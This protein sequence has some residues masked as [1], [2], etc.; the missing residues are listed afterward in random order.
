MS[1]MPRSSAA[2]SRLASGCLRRTSW[3][4]VGWVPAPHDVATRLG[5]EEDAEVAVRRRLLLVNDEP[6]ALCDSY[7]PSA[8]AGGTA[9][10]EPER[11]AGGAYGLIE[12]AE[13]PIA[14]TLQ[15]SIDDL[16]CRMPTQHEFEQLQLD[17]G[18]PVVRVLR[19]VYDSDGVAVEVQDTVAAADK[20][21][22]RY[23]V[24]MR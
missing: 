18:V 23:E 5:V 16:E 21:L 7:Y 10:A 1:S 4:S 19:T 22:L 12:D 6:V 11:I 3:R 9:L 8:V 14:R 13:G 20:H 17:P 15:R 24:T 2:N